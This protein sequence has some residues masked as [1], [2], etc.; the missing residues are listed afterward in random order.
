[1]TTTDQDTL[2]A[3][4]TP[5]PLPDTARLGPVDVV[6]VG[7]L[8]VRGRPMRAILSG[9]GIAIGIAAMVA[10]LGI[11]TASQARLTD[12]IRSL[13]TNMLSVGPGDSMFGGKVPLPEDAVDMVRRIGPVTSASATAQLDGRS[14]RRTDRI[15]P[16]VT[17]GITVAATREDLLDT[18]GGRVAKGQ[19]FNAANS[20]YPTVVLGARAAELLGVDGPNRQVWIGER[21]FTVIGVLAPVPL[22]PEVDHSALVGWSAARDLLGFDGHPTRIYERSAEDAVADV[23]NVLAAT[24]NPADPAG[25]KVSRPSDALEAQLAAK[26][27]F[28]GLFV[29]LGAVAL[30]VGGVGVANTM[31][32]SVLERRQEIGLRRALGAGRGQIRLQFLTEAVTLSGLGGVAGVVLGLIVTSGYARAQGWPLVLPWPAILGG[33]A[34]S[35]AI[36]ALAGLYPAGRAARLPPTE[37]LSSG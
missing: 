4:P 33:V 10:V 5:V 7:L 6:R 11:G 37:A 9:L 14:V 3:R 1:M 31:V 15:D 35:V 17:K 2:A 27:T 22:A 32:I 19:W 26:N 28:T 18:I 25:V 20:R 29:G 30:L 24:A 12:Q 34:A 23:R 21:W 13:G 8:G 16:R 36:G